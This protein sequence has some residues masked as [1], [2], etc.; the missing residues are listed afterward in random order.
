MSYP[1]FVLYSSF[2]T[3]KQTNCLAEVTTEFLGNEREAE[4]K[5][6]RGI[7]NGGHAI[8]QPTIGMEISAN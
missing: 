3:I 6:Y 2:N 1:L 5:L 4:L 7:L 8:K